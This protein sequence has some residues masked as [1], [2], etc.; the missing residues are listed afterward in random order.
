MVVFSS[1]FDVT[2]P[3]SKIK[4]LKG[5]QDWDVGNI[6]IGNAYGDFHKW[7]VPLKMDGL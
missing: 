7:E 1:D 2:I 3:N 4:M 6:N 5:Q